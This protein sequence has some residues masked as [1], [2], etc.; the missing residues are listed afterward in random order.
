MARPD[1]L[2]DNSYLFWLRHVEDDQKE[3]KEAFIWQ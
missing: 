3:R 2:R 1:W